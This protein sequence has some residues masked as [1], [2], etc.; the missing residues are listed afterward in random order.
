MRACP[1]IIGVLASRHS[2]LAFR[3]D[4]FPLVLEASAG[5]AGA[6]PSSVSPQESADQHTV[7]LGTG[8]EPLALSVAVAQAAVK[9]SSWNTITKM[10]EATERTLQLLRFEMG[11]AWLCYAM[12]AIT[13]VAR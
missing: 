13:M 1:I 10:S 6:P 2:S 5:R 11:V 3:A 9:L 12:S 8:I 4:S 7:Y